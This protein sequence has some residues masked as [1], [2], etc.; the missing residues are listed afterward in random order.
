MPSISDIVIHLIDR[1]RR[2]G[3]GDIL[4][5]ICD[6]KRL[7]QRTAS[8]NYRAFLDRQVD[9]LCGSP[10]AIELIRNGR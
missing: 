3:L 7:Y 8:F 10:D 2:N 6:F 1:K 5:V 4:P 9:F